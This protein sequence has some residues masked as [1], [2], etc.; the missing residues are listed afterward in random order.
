[1]SPSVAEN[2]GAIAR[3][4]LLFI[5][6]CSGLALGAVPATA[7]VKA[8]TA[9]PATQP[10]EWEK[11][12][13]HWQTAHQLRHMK[14]FWL[15]D[16]DR[17]QKAEDFFARFRQLCIEGKGREAVQGALPADQTDASKAQVMPGDDLNRIMR[18]SIGGMQAFIYLHD[19]EKALGDEDYEYLG[20][21]Y[22]MSF[23]HRACGDYGSY[24]SAEQFAG[25]ACKTLEKLL[26]GRAHPFYALC[27]DEL[28]CDKI[29]LA[30]FDEAERLLS[31]AMSVTINSVGGGD[32]FCGRIQ[33]DFGVLYLATA[34]YPQATQAFQNARRQVEAGGE[35]TPADQVLHARILENLGMLS[36]MQGDDERANQW[37]TQALAE[38]DA[39]NAKMGGKN[40][41][42]RV[43]CLMALGSVPLNRPGATIAQLERAEKYLLQAREVCEKE[44][45]VDHPYTARV[46]MLLA[47]LYNL[48][49]DPAR[50]D[51]QNAIRLFHAAMHIYERA[52]DL[53]ERDRVSRLI[54]LIGMSLGAGDYHQALIYARQGLEAAQASYG[55]SPPQLAAMLEYLGQIHEQLGNVDDARKNLNDALQMVYGNMNLSFAAQSE[56]EQLR[57]TQMYRRFMDGWLS[58]C[59]RHGDV[60]ARLWEQV[61]SWKG[62]VF[63]RQHAIHQARA[64][65]TGDVLALFKELEQ[66][67]RQLQLLTYQNAAGPATDPDRGK[68]IAALRSRTDE[69]QEELAR[70]SSS[71]AEQQSLARA[72]PA[73][74]QRLLPPGA[75]L[76]DFLRYGDIHAPPDGKGLWISQE[77]YVAFV[78]TGKKV[79]AIPLGSAAPIDELL[80]QW[81][82]N[83]LFPRDVGLKL[84]AILWE[85]L[86]PALDG[87]RL[88]LIS[89][90]GA[91]ATLPFAALPGDKEGNSYL[92]EQLA[93]ATV[94]VPQLLPSLLHRDA[95]LPGAQASALLVGAV[96]FDAKADTTPTALTT[97]QS[98]VNSAFALRGGTEG[99]WLPLPGA[100]DE[101]K[102]VIGVFQKSA[103]GVS[104]RSLQ[105]PQ[106]NKSN[107]VASVQDA[108]YLHVATHAFFAPGGIRSIVAPVGADSASLNSNPSPGGIDPGLLSG[109]VLAG[110]NRPVSFDL[111]GQSASDDG[112]LTALEVS[113]LDLRNLRVVTLSACETALGKSAGGEGLL[114]LQRAFQ[115]AGARTVVASLWKVDDRKTCELMTDFYQA[116]LAQHAPPMIALREAQLKVMGSVKSGGVT[117][118]FV[119]NAPDT[120]A[121]NISPALW[122]AWVM[123]GD[124]GNI[125]ETLNW[126]RRDGIQPIAP[127]ASL[128]PPQ[129]Q[130]QSYFL[131]LIVGLGIASGLLAVI[132][133]IRRRSR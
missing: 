10:A 53:N 41:I 30:K 126:L 94:P 97:A 87:A 57:M 99:H 92:I 25:R 112:I 73:D 22:W 49:G 105:G 133:F 52:K 23:A 55:A 32:E 83:E 54:G 15:D 56:D 75:A 77:C 88:V 78:I 132:I 31:Q 91:L 50:N 67:T 121:S 47:T 111:T 18:V 19:L 128:V 4:A 107:L 125:S 96:N 108:Q 71:F 76:V 28:A 72:A 17:L 74:I 11:I 84:R 85:K 38:Q 16:P 27:L 3:L 13:T 124:P 93:L 45:G 95:S 61:L 58:F 46:W 43:D 12:E 21:L 120:P 68:K 109:L 119:Q 89:P 36:E 79:T 64:G 90:D 39:L 114:G 48:R 115:L 29:A 122:A 65:A 116:L 110:A 5:A 129:I 42:R 86:E 2:S 106:A 8:S 62:T 37:L 104:A 113:R 123:S 82:A 40:T 59:L 14:A 20:S 118:S 100:A 98:P 131:P 1:M 34:R 7:P 33:N 51:S 69:L 101:L 102:Q 63:A 117:R 66:A 103:P 81:Q 80:Q 35:L 130:P 26:N 60:D 6:A 44:M 127:A 70:K 24:E 9:Q